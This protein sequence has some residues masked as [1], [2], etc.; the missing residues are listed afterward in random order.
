MIADLTFGN[1]N[2]YQELGYL[3]GLNRGKGFRQHNFMLLVKEGKTNTD[4]EIGFNLRVHQQLRFK[5]END[6][7]K[8]LLNSLEIYYNLK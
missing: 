4:Q 7:R 6:L 5:N 2:V 1:K 8:K 3:M